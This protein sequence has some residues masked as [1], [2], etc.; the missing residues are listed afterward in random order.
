MSTPRRSLNADVSW[1]W[2]LD[3]LESKVQSHVLPA[4]AQCPICRLG[5]V[6]IYHDHIS[7]GQWHWCPSCGGSGDMI[8]LAAK[9]WGLSIT[10]TVIKLHRIGFQVTG[11]R[12]ARRVEAFLGKKRQLAPLN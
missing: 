1:E 7:G 9:A 8:E 10:A 4:V 11:D 3:R 12:T 6:R 2:L 5:L